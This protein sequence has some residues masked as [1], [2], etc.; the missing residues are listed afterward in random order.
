MS[1]VTPRPVTPEGLVAELAERIDALTDHDDPRVLRVVVDGAPAAGGAALA[2]QLVA[3]LRRRGRDV[4]RVHAAAF[5][6][7]A[8]VR[9]EHGHEDVQAFADD[10]L[11]EDALR[12][13]VLDP[14]GPDGHRQW[15][16]S[17]RDPVSD[18][19]TREA[20]RTALDR[21]VLLLD[22]WLLLGRGLSA[23]LTVHLS[24]G[25]AALH[26]RTPEEARWTLA[27]FAG[28]AERVRPEELADLVVRVVDPRRPALLG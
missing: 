21:S 25:P 14:L 8:S 26:R 24:M 1:L 2:D 12:R 20:Y 6:R 19:A 11:D 27:A 9:L 10:W 4:L 28:Y 23:D 22:G 7:G 13:E 15:L 3:P 17:L 16:P 5:L 18:R